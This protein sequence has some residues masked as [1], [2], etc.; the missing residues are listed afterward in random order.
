[1]KSEWYFQFAGPAVHSLSSNGSEFLSSLKRPYYNLGVIAGIKENSYND[2][3]LPGPDDGLVTVES[4]KVDGMSDFIAMNNISHTQ[5]RYDSDV[6]AQV[7]H[8]LNHGKFAK[9]E[10]NLN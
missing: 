7:I 3:I 8:F 5:M 6:A 4:A 1:M 2:H 9:T 10:D